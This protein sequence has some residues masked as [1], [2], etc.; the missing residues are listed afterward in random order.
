MG[1]I[2]F[3][4]S[5]SLNGSCSI[6]SSNYRDMEYQSIDSDQTAL[7]Q[8]K[9]LGLMYRLQSIGFEVCQ[10]HQYMRSIDVVKDRVLAT[11]TLTEQESYN[12]SLIFLIHILPLV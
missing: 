4:I 12:N 6:C 9:D 5:T 3:T 2:L 8:L 11:L 10:L 1:Q 7:R